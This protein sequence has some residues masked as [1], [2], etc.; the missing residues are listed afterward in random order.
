MPVSSLYNA[1]L[2]EEYINIQ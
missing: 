2:I 1:R